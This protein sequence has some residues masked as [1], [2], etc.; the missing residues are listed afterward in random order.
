MRHVARPRPP[1]LQYNLLEQVLPVIGIPLPLV[2]YGGSALV[3]SLVGLGFLVSFARHE[4]GAQAALRDKR[5]RRVNG[6]TAGGVSRR[7]RG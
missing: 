4:P 1:Q 7:S 5:R 2:S 6:V 3:P